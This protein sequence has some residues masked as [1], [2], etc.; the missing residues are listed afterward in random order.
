MPTVPPVRSGSVAPVP[1]YTGPPGT[2]RSSQ[3]GH[4]HQHIE[5][6]PAREGEPAFVLR[7]R[8]ML[9][10]ASRRTRSL[11]IAAPSDSDSP[12]SSHAGAKDDGVEFHSGSA[13]PGEDRYPAGAA[14]TPRVEDRRRVRTTPFKRIHIGRG[15]APPTSGVYPLVPRT[16]WVRPDSA[17]KP[18]SASLGTPR[19]RMMFSGLMSR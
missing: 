18:M 16:V 13:I 7:T 5:A 6:R 11:R 12:P 1:G 3:H 4:Q 9:S 15:P 10:P 8:T 2:Q 19:T 14:G 17:T